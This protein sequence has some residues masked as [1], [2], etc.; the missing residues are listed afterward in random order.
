[1]RK[2]TL[3]ILLIFIIVAGYIFIGS[4]LSDKSNESNSTARLIVVSQTQKIKSDTKSQV[5]VN[6]KHKEGITTEDKLSEVKNT[7]SKIVKHIN[8]PKLNIDNINILY[9]DA[10]SGF[11]TVSDVYN[12]NTKNDCYLIINNKVYDV[13]SYIGY[14]PAGSRVI[15][16]RCGKEVTGIFASIHSNRAWD[17][18][19]RYQIGAVS[20]GQQ[21]L[22]PQILTA[23]SDALKKANPDSDIIYVRPKNNFYIAKIIY[24]GKFYEVHIGD[25]GEIL[26]EEIGKDESDWSL[27][28][29]DFDDV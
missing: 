29:S 18:L 10:L 22:A 25:K 16:S 20:S 21:N 8:S 27:W 7:Q 4:L 12:H 24:N 2:I 6:V 17:L 1:M 19:A 14:H 26:K 11:F 5:E 23:I 9:G 28:D 13:S 15:A 3:I